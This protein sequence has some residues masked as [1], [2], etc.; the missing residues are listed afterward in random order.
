MILQRLRREDAG[1]SLIE[2]LVSISLFAVVTVGFYQVLF[3]GATGADTAQR[4]AEISQEARLG[5][6]RMIRDTREAS[7]LEDPSATSYHVKIDFNGDGAY[8]NPNTLGDYEDLTFTYD[9]GDDEIRLNGETLIAGVEPIGAKP[10]FDYASNF[11]EYDWNGDGV[12]SWQEIDE[13]VSH[14]VTGVGNNND[15]IDGTEDRFIS[16]VVF[17]F[18]VTV[19]DRSSEFYSEAQIRNRR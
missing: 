3:S 2:V 8:E 4:L 18:R 6:N 10:I 19:D 15:L 12:S 9:A 11:L 5:F 16:S 7:V 17:S 14:G 13:A 1:L